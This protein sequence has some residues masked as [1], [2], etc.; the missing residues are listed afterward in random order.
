MQSLLDESVCSQ[1]EERSPNQVEQR[2]FHK[3]SVAAEDIE[4]STVPKATAKGIWGK[5]ARL[6]NTPGSISKKTL[7]KAHFVQVSANGRLCV[8]NS[9]LCGGD[10]N[11]VHTQLQL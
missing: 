3:L 5:A 6:L 8:M 10:V 11:C 2:R 9:A 7:K 4:L 1:M